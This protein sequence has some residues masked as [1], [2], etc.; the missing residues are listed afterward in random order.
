MIVDNLPSVMRIVFVPWGI[1]M[2]LQFTFNYVYLGTIAPTVAETQSPMT[3]QFGY[4]LGDFS[5][6]IAALIVYIWIIVGWHRFILLGE[7]P[8]GYLPN[9]HGARNMS[10]F[11]KALLIA[12]L[13]VLPILLYATLMGLLF[14]PEGLHSSEPALSVL[15]TFIFSV[16]ISYVSLRL[17]MVLP[18]V[19]IGNNMAFKESWRITES[20]S[21]SML[22]V[23][24]VL[25]ALYLI[26]MFLEQCFSG[27][28]IPAVMAIIINSV[29]T[30]FSIS[31]LTTYYGML[32]EAREL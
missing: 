2:L 9:W 29:V 24:L 8:R 20:A 28:L 4:A 11:V 1:I 30:F 15:F 16:A 10:Y 3:D 18:A 21:L 32:V 5:L 17:S 25:S 19:A 6:F 7:I 23:S 22:N 12:L 31:I 26:P 27:H 13:M 14:G